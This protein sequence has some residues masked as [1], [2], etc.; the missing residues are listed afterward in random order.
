MP[1]APDRSLESAPRLAVTDDDADERPPAPAWVPWATVGGVVAVVLLAFVAW[2]SSEET[3]P[4]DE[5]VDAKSVEPGDEAPSEDPAP[6][7]DPPPAPVADAE[8][9]PPA[10]DSGEDA[11]DAMVEGGPEGAEGDEAALDE[12]VDA[13]DSAQIDE[14]PEDDAA[15]EAAG[16]DSEPSRKPSK[17]AK[18]GGR[19]SSPSPTPQPAG[20]SKPEPAPGSNKEAS[21]TVLLA[22]AKSALKRGKAREAYALASKSY[23]KA[24]SASALQVMARAACRMGSAAKA[25]SAF[26]R[27]TLSQRSGIRSECRQHGIKLGL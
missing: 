4:P 19:Q 7:E 27:L 22:D 13:E 24:K 9:P 14:P 23:R 5:T 1:A 2:P 25:K 8:E 10:E 17:R 3:P 21:P 15:A 20:D 26:D 11:L 12:G 18:R 6:A 16:G